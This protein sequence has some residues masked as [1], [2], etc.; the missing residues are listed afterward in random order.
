MDANNIAD[1]GSGQGGQQAETTMIDNTKSGIDKDEIS[2][3]KEQAQNAPDRDQSE[4]M[5]NN[6]VSVS[7]ISEVSTKREARKSKKGEKKRTGTYNPFERETML[8]KKASEMVHSLQT[9]SAME[10]CVEFYGMTRTELFGEARCFAVLFTEGALN[11]SWE[12]LD[13]SEDMK[14]T[15][16][17]RC[18]KKFRTRAGT[19]M[20]RQERAMIALFPSRKGNPDEETLDPN[21]GWAHTEFT[22]SEVLDSD[23]MILER[24]L[25]Q[26]KRGTEAKGTVSLVLDVI[27]HVEIEKKVTIDFGFLKDAPRRNRMYFEICKALRRGKWAPL[28]KS[29]V[30]CSS[31][32]DKFD[33]VTF[34]SQDFHGGDESKLFRLEVYRWYR[35]GRFKLLGFVQTSFEK[36]STLKANDQLYWWPAPNGITSAKIVI[37]EIEMNNLDHNFALRLSKMF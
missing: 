7:R 30:R 31:E 21:G 19:E 32:A 12:E 33:R 25:K 16:H 6:V 2:G 14:C 34:D 10:L 36:L 26:G 37:Q 11:G 9:T 5:E 27:Y 1:S 3:E 35:N 29:E 24:R 28:Y 23:Q 18:F 4:P 17:M 22:V 20:D 13:R 15:G 8:A